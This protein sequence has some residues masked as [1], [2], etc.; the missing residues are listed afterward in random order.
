MIEYKIIL[1][2]LER[3][4]KNY[5][6]EYSDVDKLGGLKEGKYKK[7]IPEKEVLNVKELISVAKIFI[8]DPSKVFNPKMRMPAFKD[9]PSSV[10]E[11][12]SERLGKVGKVI[13]KKDF[14]QYCILILDKYFKVG[15]DFTNSQIKGYLEG[16]LAIAFKG[17]SIEW[18]KSILSPFIEDT[19]ETR[20]A[21]TKAEKVYRFIKVIPPDMIK[22]AK[23]V[24]RED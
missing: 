7:V 23:E 19:G 12:A 1:Q 4:R 11:I 24:T 5:G 2:N 3:L 18:N 16:D 21:K 15:D 9:L 17:K 22:R 20:K 14:I 6:L 8:A 10:Q 13:E